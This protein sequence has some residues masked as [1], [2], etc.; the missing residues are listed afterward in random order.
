MAIGDSCTYKV[1]ANCT[2][3][4]IEVD[5]ID[6]DLYIHSFKGPEANDTTNKFTPSKKDKTKIVSSPPAELQ[7]KDCKQ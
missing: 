7:I 4:V 6:V 5:S 2:W 1:F 3:P